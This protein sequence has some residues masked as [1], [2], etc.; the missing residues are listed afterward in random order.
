MSQAPSINAQD[1]FQKLLNKAKRITFQTLD[2]TSFY[3]IASGNV[4]VSEP[5][6]AWTSSDIFTEEGISAVVAM[7]SEKGPVV[8][9]LGVSDRLIYTFYREGFLPE[10]VIKTGFQLD[11][12]HTEEDIE[13]LLTALDINYV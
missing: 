8:L 5:V 9:G 3:D 2:G 12:G 11:Y 10:R 1:L 7:P 6:W 4:E 13:F